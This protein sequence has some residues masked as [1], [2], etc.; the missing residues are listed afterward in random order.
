MSK[1]RHERERL[2]T[3]ANNTATANVK[4]SQKAVFDA[5]EQVNKLRKEADLLRIEVDRN[6][7]TLDE[8]KEKIE[9]AR[10]RARALF[11]EGI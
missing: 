7:L 6:K 4:Q 10:A 1:A 2:L 5:K 8:V 3:E 9:E 11:G